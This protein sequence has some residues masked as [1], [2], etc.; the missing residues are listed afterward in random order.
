[1]EPPDDGDMTRVSGAVR[2]LNERGMAPYF[3]T[4]NSNKRSLTLDLK[5]EKGRDIVK[6]LVAGAAAV[7][8]ELGLGPEE[9]A[10]L[11][12]EGVV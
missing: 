8:G 7:L 11:R 10:A 6:R 2:A 1:M 3:L 5:T 9:I 4:Q 12:D